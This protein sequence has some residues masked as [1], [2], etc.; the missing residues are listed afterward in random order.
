M[1]CF[2]SGRIHK[3]KREGAD[4][5]R[6]GGFWNSKWWKNHAKNERYGDDKR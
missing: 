5:M 2:C 3:I 1:L 6:T 4:S